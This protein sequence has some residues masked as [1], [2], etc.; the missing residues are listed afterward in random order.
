MIPNSAN[1]HL[2][3][4]ASF[5]TCPTQGGAATDR[6]AT[7]QSRRPALNQF[8][9]SIC[10]LHPF[11]RLPLP[12]QKVDARRVGI[13]QPL[14]VGIMSSPSSLGNLSSP[15]TRTS[16]PSTP[17]Q[18][19]PLV[20]NLSL[21]DAAVSPGPTSPTTPRRPPRS[22]LRVKSSQSLVPTEPSGL[23]LSTEVGG[24]LDK[25]FGTLSHLSG[26][27]VCCMLYAV[28]CSRP[29]HRNTRAATFPCSCGSIRHPHHFPP[30]DPR[31][32]HRFASTTSL[33]GENERGR[34]CARSR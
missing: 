16:P 25:I 26:N 9:E 8:S 27:D 24:L 29:P 31:G 20:A 3:L 17:T 12:G 32:L 21:G 28:I 4:A 13:Y 15:T 6:P 5:V 30:R 33:R 11:C 22:L 2:R 14:P 23:D 34:Q 1:P 19:V 18:L 10:I 7:S